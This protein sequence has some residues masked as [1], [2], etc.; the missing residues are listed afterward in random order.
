[1]L[2]DID[3]PSEVG[4]VTLSARGHELRQGDVARI[5]ALLR[6]HTLKEAAALLG[7][8]PITLRRRLQD[9]TFKRSYREAQGLY[10]QE[11]V[12]AIIEDDPLRHLIRRKP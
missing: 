5:V 3:I 10:L 7:C 9:P 4:D 11:C 1:M 12:G 8:A 6:T 2:D